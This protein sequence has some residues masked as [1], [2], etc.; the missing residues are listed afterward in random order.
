M[1]YVW[2]KNEKIYIEIPRSNKGCIY[3]DLVFSRNNQEPIKPG[4]I[5]GIANVS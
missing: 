4:Y 3:M 5:I 2:T 1:L